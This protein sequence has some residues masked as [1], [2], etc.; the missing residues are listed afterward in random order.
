MTAVPTNLKDRMM[1]WHKGLAQV[2]GAMALSYFGTGLPRGVA[3]EWARRARIVADDMD[4]IANGKASALDETG[5]RVLDCVASP[6]PTAR[7]ETRGVPSADFV[8]HATQE[9]RDEV[10]PGSTVTETSESS[11]PQKSPGPLPQGA[12]RNADW[13]GGLDEARAKSAAKKATRKAIKK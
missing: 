12:G 9:A 5:Q 8:D 6:A 2:T 4:A 10:A 11:K 13:T 7:R 3:V 1:L